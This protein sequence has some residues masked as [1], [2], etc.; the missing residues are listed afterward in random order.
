MLLQESTPPHSQILMILL[1]GFQ[2]D[3]FCLV[4]NRI[5]KIPA[6]LQPHVILMVVKSPFL[7][8]IMNVISQMNH[9]PW[10][11]TLSPTSPTFFQ[12]SL[13]LP[14]KILNK[15]HNDHN[16]KYYSG[17]N[18]YFLRLMVVLYQLFYINLEKKKY[19]VNVD[20]TFEFDISLVLF[21][22]PHV[23]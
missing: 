17:I 10:F 12:N 18:K 20:D 7:N 19:L 6:T 14:L 4:L 11:M 1:I 23:G 16:I 9:N 21:D 13:A 2:E 15:D 22:A 3:N 8:M 5:R